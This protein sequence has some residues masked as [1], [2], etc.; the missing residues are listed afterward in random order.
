MHQNK[1]R[2]LHQSL[3]SKLTYILNPAKTDNGKY[4]T[5]FKC[6]A[7][8][9]DAEWALSHRQ[10]KDRTHR[11]SDHGVIAYQVRQSFAPGEVTPEEANRIGE[12]FAHRFLKDKYAFVVATHVDREH[13]HN[14]ILWNAV[15]LDGERKFRDFFMSGLAVRD[16]SDQ[17][18]TEHQL[19]TIIAKSKRCRDYKSWLGVLRKVPQRDML[20]ASINAALDKSPSDFEAL[21]QML[22]EDGWEIRRGKRISMRK[23]GF[24]RYARL[25][26]LGDGYD[27]ECLKAIIGGSKH[28]I[29]K[30]TQPW[31]QADRRIGL[32]IDIETALQSGKGPGYEYWAK[33]ENLKRAAKAVRMLEARGALNRDDLDPIVSSAIHDEKSL[34][35]QCHALDVEI[36]NLRTLRQHILNY[37]RTR[38]IAEQYRASGYSKKYAAEHKEELRQYRE[39][40]RAFDQ[41]GQTALPKIGDLQKQERQLIADKQEK[42]A[43]YRRAKAVSKA[44]QEAK[45]N[46]E[47]LLTHQ[48]RIVEMP[49]PAYEHFDKKH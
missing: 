15:S 5:T 26:S 7:Q 37:S 9:A 40:K 39:A 46:V 2:N 17:I 31:L 36:G 13:I 18:C 1:G 11:Q 16:L 33:R 43:E 38:K 6:A 27:E 47:S 20:R 12:E 23:A 45:M 21:L 42:Y 19:S 3:D 44:L 4:V 14:H 30:R 41:L 32:L 24:T 34:L 35:D 48:A 49:A 10:Y 22:V 28:K 29:Q 8:T 25:D